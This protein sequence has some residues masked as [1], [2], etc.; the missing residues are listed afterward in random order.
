LDHVAGPP[1]AVLPVVRTGQ[2][3]L[4]DDDYASRTGKRIMQVLNRMAH[5]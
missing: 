5:G 3:E 2:S 1:D 4:V